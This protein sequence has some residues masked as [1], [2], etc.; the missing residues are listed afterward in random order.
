[1]KRSY[2][3]KKLRLKSRHSKRIIKKGGSAAQLEI[4]NSAPAK[5]EDILSQIIDKIKTMNELSVRE[6]NTPDNKKNIE[7]TY[8]KYLVIKLINEIENVKKYCMR[9]IYKWSSTDPKLGLGTYETEESIKLLELIN[10]I[11]K[12]PPARITE[13]KNTIV[14]SYREYVESIVGNPSNNPE[15]MN[16]VK[17]KVIDI[18][19]KIWYNNIKPQ[20]LGIIDRNRNFLEK[21]TCDTE[22]DFTHPPNP[23]YYKYVSDNIINLESNIISGEFFNE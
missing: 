5:L 6:I 9:E 16:M 10:A 21:Q 13:L 22:C 20:I 8:S 15:Y 17:K 23:T 12:L 2:S 11:N 7:D 3:R 14:D 1:M 18:N 4:R 19:L